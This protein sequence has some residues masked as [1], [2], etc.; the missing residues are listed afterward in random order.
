MDNVNKPSETPEGYSYVGPRDN[1]ILYDLNIDAKPKSQRQ[2]NYGISVQDG[3][4]KG[5]LGKGVFGPAA[6]N[7]GSGTIAVT[8]VVFLN[9]KNG[10]ANNKNGKT[11][12]GITVT[13]SL[14]I[15][16]ANSSSKNGGGLSVINEGSIKWAQLKIPTNSSTIRE[17]GT[18]VFNASVFIPAHQLSRGS[19]TSASISY[20]MPDNAVTFRQPITLNWGLRKY[21]TFK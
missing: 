21:C 4:N 7:S 10:T 9:P 3:D 5:P 11:F 14:S 19:L 17:E 13:G 8:T 1:D 20:G 15:P 18:S 12:F 16:E 2:S 6:P